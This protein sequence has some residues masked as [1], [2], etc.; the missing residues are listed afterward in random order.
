MGT[1]YEYLIFKKQLMDT[2]IEV[3]QKINGSIKNELEIGD[4]GGQ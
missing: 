4:S 3:F 1:F 2:F